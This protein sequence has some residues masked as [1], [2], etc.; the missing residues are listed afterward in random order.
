M[1]ELVHA[2]IDQIDA[3]GSGLPGTDEGGV[4]LGPGESGKARPPGQGCEIGEVYELIVG[5][6][7]PSQLTEE[8]CTVAGMRARA[9]ARS[10]GTIRADS[11]LAERTERGIGRVG[12]VRGKRM[13]VGYTF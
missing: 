6:L 12:A 13:I 10:F 3:G 11:S 4:G 8:G 9:D 2:G 5:K 1:P 7:P